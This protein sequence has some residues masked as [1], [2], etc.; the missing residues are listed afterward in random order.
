MIEV[1]KFNHQVQTVE[2]PTL[3]R[4]QTNSPFLLHWTSDEW[5]HSTDTRSIATGVGIDYVNIPV[6]A[7]DAILKFT[8]FWPE[9]DRWEG[10][11]YAVA[12]QANRQTKHKSRKNGR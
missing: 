1:W 9:E 3:L 6:P 2:G 5:K 7:K 11:D 8:F 10:K 4:I 12:V